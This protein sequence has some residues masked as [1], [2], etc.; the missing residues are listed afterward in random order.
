MTKKELLRFEKINDSEYDIFT[1]YNIFRMKV[2]FNGFARTTLD[3]SKQKTLF[4][5]TL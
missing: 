4:H 2:M 1:E 3:I 5:L